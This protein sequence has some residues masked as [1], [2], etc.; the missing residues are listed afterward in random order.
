MDDCLLL[1][2]HYCLSTKCLSLFIA[3]AI[4]YL[5]CVLLYWQFEQK[6]RFY[7]GFHLFCR[8]RGVCMFFSAIFFGDSA[9]CK[10]SRVDLARET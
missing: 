5:V 2:V 4:S 10:A 9:P 1:A 8:H 7:W 6:V 3:V